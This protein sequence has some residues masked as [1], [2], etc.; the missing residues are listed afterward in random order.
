MKLST[1]RRSFGLH[2]LIRIEC[3]VRPI[4]H[5]HFASIA[6]RQARTHRSAQSV[7]HRIRLPDT[8]FQVSPTPQA[9][10]DTIPRPVMATRRMCAPQ[11]TGD[12]RGLLKPRHRTNK[13]MR[14]NR[15]PST[16]V[17]KKFSFAAAGVISGSVRERVS[18]FVTWS[19]GWE[20]AF[21]FQGSGG[22]SRQAAPA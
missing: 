13:R 14:A 18:I 15:R 20:Q 16:P 8:R 22:R 11:Q 19:Q 7:R 6:G 3:T 5:W 21:G 12:S 2:P 9:S 1:F 17:F 4:A 10:G